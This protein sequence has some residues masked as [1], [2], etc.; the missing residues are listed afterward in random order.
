MTTP[1]TPRSRKAVILLADD[2]PADVML[3]RR[4]FRTAR[5]DNDLHV[6]SDG[7]ELLEY[8]RSTGRYAPP[9][10]QPF[11]DLLLL[12]LNMPR[13]DGREALAEIRRDPKLH[14]LPAVV[15]TT[16]EQEADVLRT[17]DL[18]ANSFITKPVSIE[19]LVAVVK[20]LD[21]YWFQIVSLPPNDGA[22]A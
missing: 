19:G 3:T 20:A 14:A 12:D 4:A 15:L 6:V 10:D 22:S 21:N 5:L 2:D 18:G 16:S 1:R 17:Y 13:M 7:E 9:R 8:L 11:P